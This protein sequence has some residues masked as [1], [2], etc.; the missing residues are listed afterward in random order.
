MESSEPKPYENA[1]TD[2]ENNSTLQA[3]LGPLIKEFQLL[4]ESVNTIDSDYTDLKMTISKQKED[5]K[6]E[7]SDKIEEKTKHLHNIATEN[8]TLKKENNL[9]KTK[10]DA[11]EQNQLINNAMITCIQEGPFEQ[12]NTTK[13][14]VHEMVAVTIASGNS[15]EDLNTAKKIKIT[16]C[17]RVGKFRYNYPRPISVTFAKRDDK[18]AFLC[19]EKC[20]PEGIFTN[21]EYPLHIKHNRDFLR[22]IF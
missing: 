7:L 21:E 10:V 1:T 8:R 6:Q 12:Y 17:N 2:A 9:L 19:K 11:L 22:P 13:L 16:S 14:H 20:L 3:A 5:L 15:K 4:R 18:E